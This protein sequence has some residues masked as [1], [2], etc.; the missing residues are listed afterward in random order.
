MS[1]ITVAH[2]QSGYY[3]ETTAFANPRPDA[4]IAGGTYMWHNS[5]NNN[6]L[7]FERLAG[8][9]ISIVLVDYDRVNHP[10]YIYDL[11]LH[12]EARQPQR[13]I[14]DDIM[15]TAYGLQP[16]G[17]V[18]PT[19]VGVTRSEFDSLKTRIIKRMTRKE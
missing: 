4:V 1:T 19:R 16:D 7:S 5:N 15:V 8:D 14:V 17:S 18:S 12:A 6:H 13:W 3:I 2:A 9:S 10:K 11:R